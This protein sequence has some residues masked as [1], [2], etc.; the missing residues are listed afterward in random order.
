M[1]Q[2]V[3]WM[4]GRTLVGEVINQSGSVL[5]CDLNFDCETM[6]PWV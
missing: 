2:V 5:T 3:I 4:N 1:A 6:A